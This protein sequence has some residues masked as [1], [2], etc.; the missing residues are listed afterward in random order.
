MTCEQRNITLFDR[1]HACSSGNQGFGAFRITIGMPAFNE[2][3]HIGAAIESL[4]AQD[5]SGF[6]LLISDNGS[7]DETLRIAQAYAAIDSRVVVHSQAQ[8]LSA[9]ENFQFLLSQA[10]TDFFM[11]AGAHDLWSSNYVRG[12]SDTLLANPTSRLAVGD[13]VYIDDTSKVEGFAVQDLNTTGLK[14]AASRALALF[15]NMNRCNAFYGLYDRVALVQ[16]MDLPYRIV[17]LDFLILMRLAALGDVVSCHEVAWYRRNFRKES[18]AQKAKRHA[19]V[20]STKG[21]AL[22]LPLAHSRLVTIWMLAGFQGDLRARAE[23][24]LYALWRMVFQPA[25]LRTLF[26][27]FISAT[28]TAVK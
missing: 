9:L 22:M 6:K 5:F 24:I 16:A 1:Q 25:Q 10:D 7:Q 2:A 3:R 28:Y 19:S 8:P 27:E 26:R 20:F 11:Y 13:T 21:W 15:R 12:L 23:L 17:N 14:S 18:P 4:L